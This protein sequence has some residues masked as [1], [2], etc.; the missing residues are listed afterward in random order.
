[1]KVIKL[2]EANIPAFK[3]YFKKY[4]HEQDESNPPLDDFKITDDEPA[5]LLIENNE[6]RGAAS[7]MIYPEYREVRLARFRIFHTINNDFIS[8]NKLLNNILLHTNGLTSI[9]CFIEDKFSNIAKLWE[10]MGFQSRRYAW[11]LVMELAPNV[12]ADFPEGYELRTFRDEVDEENWC[13]VINDAFEHSLGHVR[14]TPEKL[15]HMRITTGYIKEGMKILWHS[16]KPVGTIMLD[17]ETI[18][19]EEVIFIDA[20]SVL[21]EY[22]GKGLGKN[23]LK[24]GLEFAVNYGVKKAMLS[25][26]GENEKAAEMYLKEGFK[27][28]ALYKCYYYDIKN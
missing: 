20:V 22:Q 4:S 27:K 7:L 12:K 3:E 16:D 8:Y 6:I 2:T 25:V 14:M 15:S 23:L 19:N 5:F 10:E 17:K 26:N 11:I 28:E 21:N 24:A 9:Y 13:S 18:N 1:M